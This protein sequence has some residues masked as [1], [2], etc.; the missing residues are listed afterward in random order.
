MLHISFFTLRPT[1]CIKIFKPCH[2]SLVVLWKIVRKPSFIHLS[3]ELLQGPIWHNCSKFFVI[4]TS[5][6]FI[7]IIIESFN[8]LDYLPP[9]I[10]VYG[11]N[12]F[13]IMY[14]AFF[15]VRKPLL[16][17]ILPVFIIRNGFLFYH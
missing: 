13:Y 15:G 3:T 11:I 7:V 9:R 10:I 12:L 16:G 2:T 6:F 14:R 17:T 1:L 4:E 8:L 5:V